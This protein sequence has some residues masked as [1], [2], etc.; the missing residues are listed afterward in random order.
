MQFTGGAC[1]RVLDFTAEHGRNGVL[2]QK[3]K[4][5]DGN[6]APGKYEN[7]STPTRFP[8]TSRQGPG[9]SAHTQHCLEDTKA[10]YGKKACHGRQRNLSDVMT[11]FKPPVS[12]PEGTACTPVFPS[13]VL[14][15]CHLVKATSTSVSCMLTMYHP[16]AHFGVYPKIRD[17]TCST[18]VL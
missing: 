9:Y 8:A 15:S 2:L 17:T 12:E 18:D 16:V 1:A 3:G 7:L 11:S 6:P 10:V 5:C 13:G 14:L 4:K